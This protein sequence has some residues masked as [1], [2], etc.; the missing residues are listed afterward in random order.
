MAVLFDTSMSADETMDAVDEIRGLTDQGCFVSG[1]SAVVTDIKNL[2]NKE[3]PIYVLIAVLLSSL[4]LAL[5]MDSFLAPVFF[6]LSIGMAIL[7]NLG[8]TGK[9]YISVVMGAPDKEILYQNM[10]QLLEIGA[11]A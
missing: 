7:Y 4:V 11:G 3:T 8:S 5:T 10:T 1:M 2:S 9:P 6:L